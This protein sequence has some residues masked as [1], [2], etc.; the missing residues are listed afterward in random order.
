MNDRKTIIR[1]LLAFAF[2][3]VGVSH[4]THEAFFIAI[5]PPYIPYHRFCVLF[6]GA[7]EI[8]GGIGLLVPQLRRAAG[9]GLLALLVAVYPANIHMA[10]ANPA[11][12]GIDPAPTW[13]LWARLPFQFLFMW[14][15][16]WVAELRQVPESASDLA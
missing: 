15:V 16:W 5:M 6:S 4:F 8:A 10:L 3:A 2:I 9:I 12:P 1:G 11:I 14:A 7:A 13:A